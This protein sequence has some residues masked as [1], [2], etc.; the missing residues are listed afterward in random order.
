[1]ASNLKYWA[2]FFSISKKKPS[3]DCYVCT[4]CKVENQFVSILEHQHRSD[5]G[6]FMLALT[7]QHPQIQH[8]PALSPQP[9][10]Q[11]R[12]I[13]YSPSRLPVASWAADAIW[14]CLSSSRIAKNMDC[15][16]AAGVYGIRV[17]NPGLLQICFRR[18]TQKLSQALMPHQLIHLVCTKPRPSPPYCRLPEQPPQ[19]KFDQQL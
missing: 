18:G 4:R 19:T 11:P 15:S 5:T 12:K 1:M 16:S 14:C 17:R 3:S 8:C 2:S 13:Q 9:T 6:S 10:Q 7:K